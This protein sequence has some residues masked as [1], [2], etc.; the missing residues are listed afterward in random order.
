MF[1]RRTNWDRQSNRLTELLD[2]RRASGKSFFDLTV[3]NPTECGLDY[4]QKEILSALC[5]ARSLQY[6]PDAKGLVS[7]RQAVC[8]YYQE[9]QIRVDPANV[10]L[11]ASTSEAYSLIFKLLCNPG[12]SV[13]VPKPYYPLFDYFAQLNDVKIRY[14]S[15]QYDDEWPLKLNCE[16]VKGVKAIIIVSPHNPTGAFLKKHE[17][18]EIARIAQEN[19]LALIVDEVFIDYPFAEDKRRFGST[20]GEA[21]AL[22]F[23]L[24]GISKLAGLPQMKL[25]WIV[26]SGSPSLA[27]EATGRLEILCDTF[28]SVNS[29]VQVALP[30]LIK[31]GGRV[32]SQILQRV[33]SN[34]SMLRQETRNAPCSVLPVEGG[35]Y[36][37]LRVPETRSDEEWAIRLLEDAGIYVYPGYFFDFDEY[38]CLIVSLLGGER[39]FASSVRA[40]V[41]TIE[42]NC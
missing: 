35:W 1:S 7:A 3:S 32:R 23:T 30:Q 37:I 21:E 42:Q 40:M 8:E 4:P 15:L 24:N 41:A 6:Q 9:K 31:A 29:P 13:L 36:A 2:G 19:G 27:G 18:Q 25:G 17:Q 39:I 12:E 26:V 5:N 11:T 14:Y 34:D 10:L 22:T 38:N 33:K 20:A 16:A 28:L